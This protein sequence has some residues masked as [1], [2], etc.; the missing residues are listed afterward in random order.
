M[1]MLCE[2]SL[3]SSYRLLPDTPAGHDGW[4]VRFRMTFALLL[5]VLALALPG[6]GQ[7]TETTITGSLAGPITVNNVWPN[8][9]V[10][11]G[12]RNLYITDDVMTSSWS[13]LPEAAPLF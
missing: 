7:S 12:K 9:I 13:Y 6:W 8:H 4:T 5:V 1:P 2:C 11:D 3:S 10:L